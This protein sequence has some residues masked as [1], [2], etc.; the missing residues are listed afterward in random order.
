MT[1]NYNFANCCDKIY[2]IS[3]SKNKSNRKNIRKYLS[4]YGVSYSIYN[5]IDGSKNKL[6]QKLYKEYSEWSF[7]D[8][9][10]HHLEKTYKR[11]LIRSPNAIALSLTYKKIFIEAINKKY[12][13][14]AI[15]EEDFILD[16]NID[17]HINNFFN[18]KK[19]FDLVFLGCSQHIWNNIKIIDIPNTSTKY[20][21]APQAT[22]GSFATIYSNKIFKKIIDLIDKNNSPYDS[23]AL[24]GVISNNNSYVIYPNIVI[25]DTTR[26]SSI[27]SISRNLKYHKNK[28]RWDLS[29]M[30][31][32]RD[33]WKVSI[34][35]AN[36]NNDKTIENSIRSVI[37]QTYQN[38]ELIVVDDSSEDDSSKIIKKMA[39]KDS[40]IKPI[41]LS[42]NV[43]AYEARNI[44]LEQSLGFFITMLDPDDFFLSKKIENDIYN[45]FNQTNCEIFFS[46]IYRTN[47]INYRSIKD[48]C[49]MQKISQER[50]KHIIANGNFVF[51]HDSKWQY[52]IRFGLP[53]IFVDR[54]FFDK[55]GKWNSKYRYGMDLEL[56]Q[57]YV[58]IKYNKFIQHRELWNQIYSYQAESLGIYLDKS[59]S[60]I[61]FPMTENNA[62]NKLTIQSR[63]QIHEECNTDL[64]EKYDLSKSV[65]SST[66]NSKS[67]KGV[68][69]ST[70]ETQTIARRKIHELPIDFDWQKYQ[71]SCSSHVILSRQHAIEH[72]FNC[73]ES[74]ISR[75]KTQPSNYTRP[76]KKDMAVCLCFFNAKNDRGMEKNLHKIIQYLNESKIPWYIAELLYPNQ[77]S[78]LNDMSFISIK[79][80]SY[81]FAKENLWNIIFKK[82]NTN[83]EKFL[84]M[85]A[86]ILYSDPDWYTKAS[87][88]LNTNDVIQPMEFCYWSDSKSSKYSIAKGILT[89]AQNLTIKKYHPGFAIGVKSEWLSKVGGFYDKA[90]IGNGDICLWQAVSNAHNASMLNIETDQ[91]INKYDI[92]NYTK[93]IEKY[94]PKIAYVS[95]NTAIHLSHG[96]ILDRQ[97]VVRQ[98]LLPTN[99]AKYFKKTKTGL[100]K[101]CDTNLNKS[102]F[103]YFSSR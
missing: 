85:D 7:E 57:R 23:G 28:M 47:N 100:Y 34:I 64:I 38:F 101:I 4:K 32:A 46:N 62:T 15:L 20:Y 52:K 65:D 97:Y 84:F 93:K 14:I 18:H 75:I 98:N 88:L 82:L 71:Q 58:A 89:E 3:L 90:F 94:K 68:W 59:L 79:S 102:L 78:Y 55:Y 50:S 87:S 1:Q 49:V 5:A 67:P 74:D 43:G 25:A 27:S 31:F 48:A 37:N 21:K 53:T 61:S 70:P 40:R 60:Y 10:T 24:R 16:K 86:D 81:F 44:A 19:N 6:C 26:T 33:L 29:N 13:R 96:K 30:D 22:D 103:H 54:N 36:Y 42:N 72:Y 8:P 91:Y 9:K 66:N 17:Y 51:G 39:Q 56:I 45:Y 77:K 12:K 99:H 83:Y 35:M 76:I 80:S 69:V 2:V 73:G 41:L 11:K 92:T 95:N 63:E